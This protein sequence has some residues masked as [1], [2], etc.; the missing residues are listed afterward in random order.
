VIRA[1]GFGADRRELLAIFVGGC[2][3][4]SARAALLGWVVTRRGS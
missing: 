1:A 3:G 2:A 4:A